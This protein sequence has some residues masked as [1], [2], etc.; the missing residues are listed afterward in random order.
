METRQEKETKFCFKSVATKNIKITNDGAIPSSS[1]SVCSVSASTTLNEGNQG[2]NTLPSNLFGKDGYKWSDTSPTCDTGKTPA[3]NMVYIRPGPAKEL[4]EPLDVFSLFFND[5]ILSDILI[6]TNEGILVTSMSELKALFVLL[7]LAAALE[8]NH[9]S[10]ELLF[11]ESLSGSRYRVT[12]SRTRFLATG[13]TFR[14]LEDFD[15]K[16]NFPNF[17]G[18]LDEKH[19]RI[20]SPAHSGSLFLLAIVDSKYSFVY[21]DIGAF[22]KAAKIEEICT[23][24]EDIQS[25]IERETSDIEASNSERETFEDRYFSVVARAQQYGKNIEQPIERYISFPEYEGVGLSRERVL[26]MA[27]QNLMA[28]AEKQKL[29]E[30]QKIKPASFAIGD[31]VLVRTHYQSSTADKTIKKFFLLVEGPYTVSKQVGPNSYIVR[32][33]GEKGP[34]KQKIINLGPYRQFPGKQHL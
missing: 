1:H 23:E 6:Y 29:R 13:N 8:D 7:I 21:V 3:R 30:E 9:L 16:A 14:G 20:W 25:Q 2:E 12:I 4:T 19:I 33:D 17:M 24:F 5:D 15:K 31:K 27:K 18:A 34:P 28:K 10:A 11:D 32:D 22:A 26:I